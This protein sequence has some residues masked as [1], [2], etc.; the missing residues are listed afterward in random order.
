[1]P[2]IDFFKFFT[3]ILLVFVRTRNPAVYVGETVPPLVEIRFS[4]L[5]KTVG[6]GGHNLPN[7]YYEPPPSRIFRPCDGPASP[8]DLHLTFEKFS[9]TN[10]IFGLFRIKSSSVNLIFQT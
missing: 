1:M 7:Q 3:K 10:L 9:W 6:E 5:P 4:D 2:I 8:I